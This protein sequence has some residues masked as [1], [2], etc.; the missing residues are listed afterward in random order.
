[1][2]WNK[3]HIFLAIFLPIQMLLMQIVARNPAF[4]ERYFENQD[5]STAYI[6]QSDGRIIMIEK[7]KKLADTPE[8]KQAGAIHRLHSLNSILN[9]IDSP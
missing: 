8:G 2:K 4:I 9:T 7:N 6:K 5:D 1:M 3:K